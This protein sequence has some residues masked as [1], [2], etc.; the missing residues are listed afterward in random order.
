MINEIFSVLNSSLREILK[1]NHPDFHYKLTLILLE[2]ETK[3]QWSGGF[4][5]SPDATVQE[6]EPKTSKKAN[7]IDKVKN[8]VKENFRRPIKIADVARATGVST[9]NFSHFFKRHT[10]MKFCDYVNS[11]RVEAATQDLRSSNHTIAEIADFCGFSTPAYFNDV[12][13][14]Y[15][16]MTPGEFRRSY[17]L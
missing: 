17:E 8:Y 3:K 10:Q 16:G 7:K 13:K 4:R 15:K 2:E 11:I 6:E 1:A 9:N 5:I 14:Q 12:F